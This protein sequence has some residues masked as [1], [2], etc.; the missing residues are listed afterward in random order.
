MK[1]D[2]L[3]FLILYGAN[4]QVHAGGD[5]KESLNKLDATIAAK[6]EK[7]QRGLLLRR[8]MSSIPGLIID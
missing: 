7:R 3:E 4:D 1:R 5:L 2:Q 8:S 6:N